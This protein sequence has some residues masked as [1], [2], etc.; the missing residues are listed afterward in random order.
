MPRIGT[1]T[2]TVIKRM[3]KLF[4]TFGRDMAPIFELTFN[5]DKPSL[6]EIYEKRY[7]QYLPT[8]MPGRLSE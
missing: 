7:G 1:T 2:L 5:P 3:N 6:L 4:Y 8:G